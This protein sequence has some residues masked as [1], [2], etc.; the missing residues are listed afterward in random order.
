MVLPNGTVTLGVPTYYLTTCFSRNSHPTSRN[1]LAQ[2]GP[3]QFIISSFALQ[4]TPRMMAW[5]FLLF[6]TCMPSYDWL[7][8]QVW[9]HEARDFD[10]LCSHARRA[11][12]FEMPDVSHARCITLR[13]HTGTD[14]VGIMWYVSSNF[15]VHQSSI[16]ININ[17]CE[18]GVAVGGGAIAAP[19]G[20][21]AKSGPGPTLVDVAPA[22][23][24]L[25]GNVGCGKC[26]SS[27]SNQL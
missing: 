20:A 19:Q 22:D 12:W 24:S 15:V 17:E 10:D 27:I 14:C 26:T 13:R 23:G 7:Q 1:N 8:V 5:G 9:T 21:V 6:L 4:G 11:Q 16:S 18:T 25:F 3:P 2:L